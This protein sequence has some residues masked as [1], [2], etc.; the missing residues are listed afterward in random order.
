MGPTSTHLL[1]LLLLTRDAAALTMG[2]GKTLRLAANSDGFSSRAFDFNIFP[3][4]G[5]HF[6][7]PFVT[8]TRP[9]LHERFHSLQH[10]H[11]K[12]R[13]HHH[14]DHHGHQHQGPRQFLEIDL[15]Y[16]KKKSIPGVRHLFC[17]GYY[18]A[19]EYA[20]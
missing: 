16:A 4:S 5:E 6:Q 10:H 18:C 3:A 19:F 12:D 1:I 20:S 2:L 15:K 8:I 7:E 9:H 14:H 17:S 13:H 11:H